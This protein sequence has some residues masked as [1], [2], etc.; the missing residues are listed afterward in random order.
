ME[1]ILAV[2]RRLENRMDIV[3]LASKSASGGSETT[4]PRTESPAR[5][6]TA[7]EM[8]KE[9]W[10]GV[11]FTELLT[12]G[13]YS[14]AHLRKPLLKISSLRTAARIVEGRRCCR[15]QHTTT[16]SAKRHWQR[17]RTRRMRSH[18]RR[19]WSSKRRSFSR[20]C[21]RDHSLSSKSSFLLDC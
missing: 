2:L 10:H 11:R 16:R 9:C 15:R 21:R 19:Q 12:E 17:A 3:E 14:G 1:S 18:V 7:E 4:S 5:R 6:A 20:L 13:L 8:P